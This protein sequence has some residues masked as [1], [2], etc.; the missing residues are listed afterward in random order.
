MKTNV[1]II[2]YKNEQKIK[3]KENEYKKYTNF[4]IKYVE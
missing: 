1:Y 2:E 4:T 3:N